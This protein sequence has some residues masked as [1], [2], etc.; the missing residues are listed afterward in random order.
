MNI[1]SINSENLFLP[2]I[3]IYIYIYGTGVNKKHMPYLDK[4]EKN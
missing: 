1:N 4:V 3:Y 2:Y